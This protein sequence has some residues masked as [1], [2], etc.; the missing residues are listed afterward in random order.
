MK[1]SLTLQKYKRYDLYCLYDFIYNGKTNESL[2]VGYKLMDVD[3][4]LIHY[5]DIG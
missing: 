5:E 1:K 3:A 2:E 4:H